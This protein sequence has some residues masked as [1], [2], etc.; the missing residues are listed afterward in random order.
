MPT[1]YCLAPAGKL[2]DSQKQQ[3]ANAITARHSEATGAPSWFVQVII[4]EESPARVRYIGGSPA[5]GHLWIHGD[6]RAGRTREQ[7][8]PLMLNIMADVADI[9]AILR[10][11]IWIYLNNIE[12]DQ[13]VEF[14]HVLPLPGEEQQWF[15]QLPAPLQEK[16][17]QLGVEHQQF[18]L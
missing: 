7:L 12:A 3:I 16:L 5:G 10:E 4:E 18:M 14:G 17:R 6:I 11:D 8:Q 13:M 1:Y 2:S 15:G 9:S